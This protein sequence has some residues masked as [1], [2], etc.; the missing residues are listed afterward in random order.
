MV[1]DGHARGI[2]ARRMLRRD[3]VM[4]RFCTGRI[5]VAAKATA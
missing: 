3:E 5:A 4:R 1:G 2:A